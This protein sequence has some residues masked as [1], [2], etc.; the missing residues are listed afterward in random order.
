MEYPE[1]NALNIYTDGSMLPGPRRGGAGLLFI[2]LDTFG[3][4]QQHEEMLPGFAGATQNQMELEAPIQGLKIAT[5]RR[6]PFD[7]STY[8]KI[9]IKTDATYVVENF[10]TA[11]SVWSKNGW[12]TKQGKPVDNAKQWKELVRLVVLSGKQGRPV[13]FV[14]VPGKKSPRTKA[15]DKLAKQSARQA[16]MRQLNPSEVRRKRTDQ[17]I[18]IGS[19]EMKG[20]LMTINIFKSEYQPLHRLSKYWYSVVSKASPYHGR[21]S[22]IY[23]E[24]HHLRR[25]TYRVRVNRDTG[26]PRIVKE[27][28]EVGKLGQ[29]DRKASV[30]T[31]GS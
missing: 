3:R 30:D 23:S 19:V 6:P 20:Q 31:E 25:R 7:P 11:V 21:A 8:R 28:G 4:E 10:G 12:T 14:L 18:Q 22:I 17:P 2:V 5:G 9:V 16:S 13:R 1:E 29:A 24:L 26:N 27:F 15:V